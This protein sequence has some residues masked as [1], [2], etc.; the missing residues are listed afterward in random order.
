M[1]ATERKIELEVLLAGQRVGVLR[2]VPTRRVRFNPDPEWLQGG[3]RPRLGW[4][5]LVDARLRDE[6]TLLP[7]WFENLLPERTNPLRRRV[8]E[9]HGLHE[10]DGPALLEVLGRDLPGAVE[11]RGLAEPDDDTEDDAATNV[12][13]FAGRL[14]FSV[15]GM[16]PK[17]SMIRRRDRW[18]LPAKDELGDWYVKFSGS[19]YAEVSAVEAAT[20]S[21]ARAAGLEIPDHRLISIDQLVGVDEGFM[22][23]TMTAFAIERFDRTPG[24]RIHQEDFAQALNFQPYD[25]YG[26]TGRLCVSYDS[27]ARLVADACGDAALATF[28]ERVA[29]MVACGD[30][31]A[32]LKNWSFQWPADQLRPRLSP[33]YDLV[34]TVSW[35]E[36]DWSAEHEPETALPLGGS[37]RLA[38]LDVERLRSFATTSRAPDAID[39]FMAALERAKQAW[40]EQA[41]HAPER[42]RAGLYEH[43]RRVPVLRSLGLV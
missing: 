21:W 16:Q 13:S 19:E 38:D 7:A 35:P 12:S 27:L 32:H 40:P 20:M 37:R 11:V 1:S 41:P 15:A 18:M 25:K 4:T 43:W 2:G 3:Q 17:L 5:F 36:F 9:H 39:R 30:H 8:C 26:G 31:D 24:G 6:P 42:M 29:F 14:R 33:C 23:T 34:A 28:I 10:H 22:G